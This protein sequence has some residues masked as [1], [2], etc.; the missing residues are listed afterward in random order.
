[1]SVTT[2]AME[3]GVRLGVGAQ[4]AEVVEPK[5]VPAV[6]LW[7]A[8][9]VLTLAFMAY[10]VVNWVTGPYFKVVPTGPTPLPDWMKAEQTALQVILPAVALGCLYWFVARP[11]RRE[12]RVGVD[13]IFAIAF[14]TLSFQDPLS[15]WAQPWF[16]Y[17]SYPVNF[18]SWLAGVPGMSAYHAPGKMLVEPLLIIPAVYVIALLIANAV[19]CGAMRRARARWPR[20]SNPTLIGVCFLAMIV[21]D[22]IFEGILFLPLGIWETFTAT[23]SLRFFR[24]DR[25]HT[26]FERG[27]DEVNAPAGR[28]VALRALAIIAGC[29]L[30]ML[31][32]YTIPNTIMSL[33]GHSWPKDLQQRSY[34]TTGICGAGTNRLCPGPTTPIVRNGGAYVGSNATLVVPPGARLEQIVP[35]KTGG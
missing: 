30:V 33:N 14:L 20:M 8:G 28:K 25:G 29:N 1:M 6:K 13:G 12:R 19:G 35:F 2:R 10:V 3:P 11:W 32:G 31:C 21:F 15:S 22:F 26:L 24:D 7:A 17:N 5:R 23:A 9:G 4:V 16:T 18:G 34:L 27:I